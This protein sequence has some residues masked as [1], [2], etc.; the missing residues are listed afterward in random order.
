MFNTCGDIVDDGDAYLL[1]DFISDDFMSVVQY[2]DNNAPVSIQTRCAD[3]LNL[4]L[5]ADPFQRLVNITRKRMVAQQMTCLSFQNI[6]LF[7]CHL[8]HEPNFQNCLYTNK[9]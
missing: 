5:G 9:L 4:T 3:M 1:H 6:A 8:C 2:N 7:R